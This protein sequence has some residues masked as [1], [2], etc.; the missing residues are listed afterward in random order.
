[1]FSV[2]YDFVS[3]L[4]VASLQK[5]KTGLDCFHHILFNVPFVNMM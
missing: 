4:E 3:V 2:R 1:V 5:V